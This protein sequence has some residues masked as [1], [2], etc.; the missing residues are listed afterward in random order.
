[1]DP[2]IR[3][4]TFVVYCSNPCF[5]AMTCEVTSEIFKLIGKDGETKMFTSATKP[6][7]SSKVEDGISSSSSTSSS[8]NSN[9]DSN[10]GSSISQ[11]FILPVSDS[12]CHVLHDYAQAN[13]DPDKPT[14]VTATQEIVGQLRTT[15]E[16]NVTRPMTNAE[17][18]LR[19]TKPGDMS[20][21]RK[22][23][24]KLAG[25]CYS[26]NMRK[27]AGKKI[28]DGTLP[29]RELHTEDDDA[30][31]ATSQGGSQ[32]EKGEDD[33]QKNEWMHATVNDEDDSMDTTSG[34]TSED[35][36]EAKA[37]APPAEAKPV[38]SV[39]NKGTAEEG[40]TEYSTAVADDANIK[41]HS[42]EKKKK[43]SGLLESEKR[44]NTL[45]EKSKDS[46]FTPIKTYTEK[47]TKSSKKS[48]DS[49]DDK[50][51][52][53]KVVFPGSTSSQP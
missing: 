15:N 16:T 24:I 18:L 33:K 26:S 42:K 4:M 52:S 6:A 14:N 3:S 19:D 49:D 38:T 21:L 50:E 31:S 32:V 22:L 44:V 35:E 12:Q 9:S 17:V 7:A 48:Q 45:D 36:V 25:E 46:T 5:N 11:S 28:V 8:S 34:D 53:E 40:G 29:G 2:L 41:S 51:D 23:I 27:L 30:T 37:D 47:I 1:M 10:S 13:T 39:H 43:Q 20:G